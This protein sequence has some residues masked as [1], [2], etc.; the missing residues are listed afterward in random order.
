MAVHIPNF[1]DLL[2]SVPSPLD[3]AKQKLALQN[4]QTE[5]QFNQFKLNEA[6]RQS[7]EEQAASDTIRRHNG[8]LEAALPELASAAPR[9]LPHFAQL[10]REQKAA[11]LNRQTADFN[12]QLA[13]RKAAEENY[14]LHI[15]M[16][17]EEVQ[18]GQPGV[19]RTPP[20]VVP[21]G[22]TVA[23]L[24][25][26]I[27][28]GFM[29]DLPLAQVTLPAAPGQPEELVTPPSQQQLY[30]QKQ[31]EAWDKSALEIQQKRQEE[32]NKADIEI[33]TKTALP[34]QLRPGE[35]SY[36]NGVL[37][38]YQPTAEEADFEKFYSGWLEDNNKPRNAWTWQEARKLYANAK[39]ADTPPVPGRDVPYSK[40][41][42]DQKIAIANAESAGRSAANHPD[43]IGDFTKTGEDFLSTIPKQWQ[44]TVRKIAAYDEDP[45][46]VTTMRGG[47]R[48]T[49]MQWVNQYNPEYKAD[50]FAIRRPTRQAFTTGTQGQQINAI[51]TAIGHIGLIPKLAAAMK[52]GS[53]VPGNEVYNTVKTAFGSDAVTNF[54]TLKDALSGEVASVLAKGGATVSGIAD[55]KAHIKNAS[56]P[57]Q[58]TGYVKTL[59]PIMGS[60][61]NEFNFQYHQA[62]GANDPWQALSPESKATLSGFG[63]NPNDLMGNGNAGASAPAKNPFR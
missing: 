44:P 48:E 18:A 39:K 56:S 20:A 57:E 38:A 60:K 22:G 21:E 42:Q 41:V 6:Q 37:R 23:P 1:S 8:D 36:V 5:S 43:P 12:R 29:K 3:Q 52:N 31:K 2:N 50:Q 45:A 33:A 35:G 24:P 32:Q 17:A 30:R 49:V 54:D 14:K 15:G 55:A 27:P 63:V 34:I 58:L 16:P 46:K 7:Q 40:D 28:Q 62:M 25:M 59:L 9:L 53:F 11:D 61:L 51:N 4:L 10:V 26:G 47:M 19:T 13:A